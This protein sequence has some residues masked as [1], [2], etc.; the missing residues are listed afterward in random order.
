MPLPNLRGLNFLW[1][2]RDEVEQGHVNRPDGR[3][4]TP[5]VPSVATTGTD[6][7]MDGAETH[8]ATDC[9]PSVP[10]TAHST[11]QQRSFGSYGME[12]GL[13]ALSLV[14]ENGTVGSDRSTRTRH[15]YH[16][17]TDT[18]YRS[19]RIERWLRFPERH[20]VIA[21]GLQSR[22]F[23][24]LPDLDD[25][26]ESLRLLSSKVE[27]NVDHHLVHIFEPQT[28]FGPRQLEI[29]MPPEDKIPF[30]GLP[31]ITG[32]ASDDSSQVAD[33]NP[34][35][36]FENITETHHENFRESLSHL[37]AN[38]QV[39]ADLLIH[40][41]GAEVNLIL[42]LFDG[43]GLD[44][45]LQPEHSGNTEH[46][47]GSKPAQSVG[48]RVPNTRSS[49]SNKRTQGVS[50]RS[51]NIERDDN[52]KDQNSKRNK[53]DPPSSLPTLPVKKAT[54][55]RFKCPFRA[56]CC[57]THCRKN[58]RL[59]TS[60][61]YALIHHILDHF[62]DYHIVVRC[63]R[64]YMI[65]EG[66]TAVSSK[67]DHQRRCN[68]TKPPIGDDVI[69]CD[70]KAKLD[71]KLRFR[72]WTLEN[73]NDLDMKSWILRNVVTLCGITR[74]KSELS[75]GDLKKLAFCERELA[76]WYTIW[77]TL[78]ESLPV[79]SHPCKCLHSPATTRTCANYAHRS[80]S[81]RIFRWLRHI[82]KL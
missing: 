20:E 52:G 56:K 9:V 36:N 39:L 49:T 82:W 29:R 13:G 32:I 1:F 47:Q 4:W 66:L 50:K 25:H 81:F 30:V 54:R 11:Q 59:S 12:E 34:E 70:M 19:V 3:L 69:D 41:L 18:S 16:A 78:F 62:K 63:Q 26:K 61:G 17:K 72:T 58:G 79:P 27:L 8:P 57:I 80:P 10:R 38:D 5:N 76:K 77:E 64:C 42:P 33:L 60:Q 6:D 24:S 23:A 7:S 51:R 2:G 55:P 44:A 71:E 43:S 48:S 28:G 14:A 46:A 75:D 40:R 68:T 73:E 37:A 31:D 22:S 45:L 74:P 67:N 15:A 21:Y 65:F 53:K 35:D